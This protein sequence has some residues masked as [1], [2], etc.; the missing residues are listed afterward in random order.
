MSDQLDRQAF[1]KALSTRL[2]KL[3]AYDRLVINLY[4]SSTEILSYFTTAD[5]LVVSALSNVRQASRKTVASMVLEKREPVVI[6]DL[7]KEFGDDLEHPMAEAGLKTTMAFPLIVRGNVLGTLHC[8]FREEPTSLVEIADF[9][10]E[11]CEHVSI[12]VD[13][14]LARERISV[15]ERGPA[16]FTMPTPV[17]DTGDGPV[18]ESQIMQ[19]IVRQMQRVAKLDIPV[20]LTGETGTGKTMLARYIH[21]CS[22]RTDGHF[23][24]VNCPALVSSLFESELFGHGKGAFT[25]ATQHRMGRVELAQGGTLFLDEIG[26]LPMELQSKLLHVLEENTFER[27]GESRSVQADFRLITATNV[28]LKAA[29]EEQRLRTDLYYRLSAVQIT[30]P[31]LRERRE[32]I[33]I[34]AKRISGQLAKSLSIPDL[35]FSM[36]MMSALQSHSWPGNIR[37]LR[38]VISRLLISNLNRPVEMRDV[39]D[40]LGMAGAPVQ[41]KS[42]FPTL[43]EMEKMHIEEALRR[44]GGA[45][46]GSDGAAALLDMPRTTLQYRLKKLGIDA[47]KFSQS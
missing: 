26:D 40:A 9:L 47:G 44:T 13:N 42:G 31:A 30:V 23:V 33:P 21:Q 17:D 37:E 1:F 8:S 38:N 22:R 25:G 2:K 12:W 15:L 11:L 4:D 19:D 29:M 16:A 35:R 10:L 36:G 46:A 39:R 27:V 41:A 28:D 14:I 3:I 20:L 34:I 6:T 43:R 32:D 45:L 18:F 24:K 7:T 5:G